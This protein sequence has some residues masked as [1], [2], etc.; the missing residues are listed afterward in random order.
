MSDDL[1]TKIRDAIASNM[2]SV[3]LC[4]RVWSAWRYGT[5]SEDDFTAAIESDQFVNDMATAVVSAL[6]DG[7]SM[8][9]TRATAFLLQYG[10]NL[11]SA[12]FSSADALKACGIIFET[13]VAK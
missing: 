8:A 2:T 7:P 11:E 4:N 1:K 3:Y 9:L 10:K 5:M 12:G 13:K 6:E